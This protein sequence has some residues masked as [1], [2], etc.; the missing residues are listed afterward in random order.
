MVTSRMLLVVVGNVERARIEKLVAPTLGTLPHGNYKWT[1][2]PDPLA[3]PADV[4][5]V[6]R[7]LPTNYL[8]GY[9]AGPRSTSP[10]YQALRIATSV[11]SGRLFTESPRAAQS[12][13]RCVGAVH[14][15]RD[16]I[17][18]ALRDDGVPGLGARHHA[19]RDRHA[20]RTAARSARI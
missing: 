17:G 19:P 15:A 20:C 14:R 1:P 9:Y 7:P 8:L 18:R 10:D 16:L 3:R 11:L 13:L 12:H 2:P 5:F 6:Q 4:V